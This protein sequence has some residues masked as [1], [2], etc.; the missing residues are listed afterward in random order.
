MRPDSGPTP[1][2]LALASRV[3]AVGGVLVPAAL[4]ADWEREWNAELWY[5]YRSLR[6]HGRLSAGDAAAFVLRS[7]GSIVDA[8]RLRVGDSQ[9][10]TESVAAVVTRWGQHTTVVAAALLFL[11]IGIAADALLIAFGQL[12]VGDPRS[13]WSRLA[14][15]VR[16][17]ILAIIVCCGMALL[18]TGAAS[19][20][21]L[22]RSAEPPPGRFPRAC[23]S[24]LVLV[25]GI[26]G[27]LGRWFA[28]RIGGTMSP[29]SAE[30]LASVDLDAAVAGGWVVS[31]ALWVVVLTVLRTRRRARTAA[32]PG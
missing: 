20:A 12:A 27:G 6:L 3:V 16:L 29:A 15:E 5:L 7:A 4:R 22:L 28:F 21:R 32:S 25:A 24:E 2:M 18:V 30:W 1:V 17:P 8:V 26:T 23:A 10:W 13:G 31:W 19:A 11:S 9:S 14:T